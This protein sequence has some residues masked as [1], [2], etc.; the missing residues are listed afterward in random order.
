[1]KCFENNPLV[2]KVSLH[3]HA[4]PQQRYA[5]ASIG[6]QSENHRLASQIAWHRGLWTHISVIASGM[7]VHQHIAVLCLCKAWGQCRHC[8]KDTSKFY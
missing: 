1:M 8:H 6:R 3:P 5:T 2:R 4:G 7:Y